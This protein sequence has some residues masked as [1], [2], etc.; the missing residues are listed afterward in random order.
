MKKSENVYDAVATLIDSLLGSNEQQFAS[1]LQHRM[2][3]VSWT[4]K[5]ELLEELQSLL[6]D[7]LI[8]NSENILLTEQMKNVLKLITDELTEL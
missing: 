4:T 1:I 6:K 2:Y 8:G 7:K 5:S 3:K